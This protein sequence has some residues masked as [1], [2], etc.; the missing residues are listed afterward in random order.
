MQLSLRTIRASA[1]AAVFVFA[2]A[3]WFAQEEISKKERAKLEHALNTVL[4]T[5]QQAVRSWLKEN[6]AATKLWANSPEI[7][8]ATEQLLLLEQSPDIL[9]GNEAQLFLRSWFQPLKKAMGYKGYFIIAPNNINL[10]SNRNQNVGLKT[11]LL[12]QPETL[13]RIW[14]GETIV[15][16]PQKAYVPLTDK[17]GVLRD[18]LPTMFIGTPILDDAGQPIAIFTFRLNPSDDFTSIFQH[19]HLGET[20]E[21]YAFDRQA[22]LI[23]I[24]RFDKELQQAGLISAEQSAMLNI[25]IRNPG[26]NLMIGKRPPLPR[27]QQA[28]TRMAADAVQGNAGIDLD[29]YRDYRGVS[30]AGAWLWD[31]ELGFGIATEQDL[32]EAYAILR[33]SRNAL[34]VFSFI[35]ILLT[36]A[37]ASILTQ[38]QL[39]QRSEKKFRTLLESAPDAMV[40]FNT[41]GIISLI[42]EQ[43]EKLFG[44]SRDELLGQPIEILIS[45]LYRASR[46]K[47]QDNDISQPAAHPMDVETDLFGQKKDAS[48]IP[49]EISLSHLE[50]DEGMLIASAIRDISDRKQTEAE[51]AKY[52]DHLQELVAQRTAALEASNRELEAYSHSIAHDLRQPLRAIT[53]FSQILLKDAKD[54]LS[55]EEKDSLNRIAAAGKKMSQLIEDILQ[56]SRITR[57]EL[58]LK[59]VDLSKLSKRILHTLEKSHPDCVVLTQVQE[60]LTSKCDPRLIEVVLQQLLDNAWKFTCQSSTAKIEFASQIINDK[61]VFFVR[62][63]GVGFDMKYSDKLFRPF[64][65]PHSAN[66]TEV[67]GVGLAMAK[68]AIQRH[69]GKIWAESEP[70]HGATFYFTLG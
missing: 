49:V 63:N 52:R 61:P 66:Q 39:R 12:N 51:L 19:G 8:T 4:M 41:E 13:Q 56:L 43:T 29:G 25:E 54:K 11:P 24:S 18:S 28:L 46:V 30:V 3:A 47:H 50:S 70:D 68:R 32:D 37:T 20:G 45:G 14:Q 58:N 38:Q 57:R 59:T 2:G 40:I 53:S 26:T 1:I 36:L 31:P 34:Y 16:L 27:E 17:N 67:T 21:T 64:Q 55:E 69:G 9:L 60:G 48:L 7:R 22:R 6:K 62:D 44:Y 10:A 33:T 65:Y 42:N 5:T 35:L 15:S 23:S